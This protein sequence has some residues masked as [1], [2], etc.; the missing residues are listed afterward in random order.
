LGG[1][2][3]TA[4]HLNEETQYTDEEIIAAIQSGERKRVNGALRLLL[5]NPALR[6]SVRKMV[7][8]AGLDVQETKSLLIESLAEFCVKV[9]KGIFDPNRGTAIRT[10]ITEIAKNKALTDRR[11]DIREKTRIGKA[12]SV[13]PKNPILIDHIHDPE[14]ALFQKEQQNAM[15]AALKAIGERC[16]RVLKLHLKGF[17]GQEIANELKLTL[18]SSKDALKTCRKKLHLYLTEHDDV[19]LAI[20]GK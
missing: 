1:N 6:G 8:M 19:R 5:D 17:S 16:R 10:Y 20:L 3:K 12:L 9:E 4:K 14:Q 15:E 7:Q 18:S 13:N 2:N 11:T